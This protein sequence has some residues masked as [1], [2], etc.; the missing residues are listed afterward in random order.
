MCLCVCLCISRTQFT[1]WLLHCL[2]S[3]YRL[4][5]T[6]L[7][8]SLQVDYYFIY[9]VFRGWLLRCLQV[10]TCFQS[11]VLS[12]L[13]RCASRRSRSKPLEWCAV[14]RASIPKLKEAACAAEGKRA[15]VHARVCVC[16][17]TWKLLHSARKSWDGE[18]GA[19]RRQARG[20]VLLDFHGINIHGAVILFITRLRR[21]DTSVVSSDVTATAT[22]AARAQRSFRVCVCVRHAFF[23]LSSSLNLLHRKPP[24][25]PHPHS[26]YV[27]HLS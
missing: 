12:Y 6:W 16:W 15:H 27:G 23:L 19:D 18:C 21:H 24:L 17:Q 7:T 2:H 8:Q 11:L 22:A 4:I 3:L 9:T 10:D 13:H 5:T 14:L 26:W 1:C 25:P 20:P